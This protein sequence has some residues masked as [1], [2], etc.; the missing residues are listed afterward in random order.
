MELE[1]ILQS[2]DLPEIN[3]DGINVRESL[4]KAIND[5]IFTPS[6]PAS[7]AANASIFFNTDTGRLSWKSPAGILM[8]FRMQLE[9]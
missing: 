1:D 9:P 5:G 3:L 8:R 6:I 2:G 4:M 7:E